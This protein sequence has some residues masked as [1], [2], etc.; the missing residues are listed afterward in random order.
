MHLNEHRQELFVQVALLLMPRTDPSHAPLVEFLD[1]A[2][3][4]LARGQADLDRWLGDIERIGPL[5]EGEPAWG[6]APLIIT[7]AGGDGGG[8]AQGVAPAS[9]P[10]GGDRP[11]P[12]Q[13]GSDVP[14]TFG[15]S[16]P[17]RK[18]DPAAANGHSNPFGPLQPRS[19]IA[20][21][22]GPPRGTALHRG[23][24]DD[25]GLDDVQFTISAQAPAPLAV[26][27]PRTDT[28]T[29]AAASG[30][31]VA[32]VTGDVV[33]GIVG[34]ATVHHVATLGA[35]TLAHTDT[36]HPD[37]RVAQGSGVV[38]D[39]EGLAL[40]HRGGGEVVHPGSRLVNVGAGGANAGA[41]SGQ[42]GGPGGQ[43]GGGGIGL[44]CDAAVPGDYIYI[45]AEDADLG[46]FASSTELPAGY[47]A[48]ASTPAN[49]IVGYR[50]EAAAARWLEAHAATGS[51]PA[52]LVGASA[53]PGEWSVCW[54]NQD[55]EKGLPFDITCTSQ[56]TGRKL[57]VEAQSPSSPTTA[58]R[59][60]Q[61]QLVQTPGR[62][63]RC[64]V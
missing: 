58:V 50:G 19:M 45:A 10:A 42:T 3:L 12:D 35:A 9:D 56:R 1:Q 38:T 53:P 57:F 44:L 48:R 16:I 8:S 25:V 37:P 41:H 26:P 33:P 49:A 29:G 2:D 59:D 54:E 20:L 64:C 34:A 18:R 61:Q 32:V 14:E 5:P 17:L 24:V 43:G 63:R 52:D 40:P 36:D 51:L 27:V 11:Q 39:L 22:A 7:A 15:K 31:E 23:T 13:S 28:N 4:R 55:V 62:R 21:D 46:E 30:A 6:F 47:H 60:S